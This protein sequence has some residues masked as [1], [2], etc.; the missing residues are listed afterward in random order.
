M[1]DYLK[2][3][4]SGFGDK[5]KIFCKQT[6]LFKALNIHNSMNKK[7]LEKLENIISIMP[8]SEKDK[9]YKKFLDIIPDGVQSYIREY[10]DQFMSVLVEIFGW[11][12]LK[13]YYQSY[14]PEFT[15]TPDLVVADNTD[16]PIAAMECKR[17]RTS[18]EDREYFERYQVEARD[19][20]TSIVSADS[21]ENPFLRKLM[22]TLNTA[23]KQLNKVK[24]PNSFIFIH[25]SWDVSAWL[26]KEEVIDRIKECATAL[27]IRGVDLIAFENYQ[28][29]NPIINT[30][31]PNKNHLN[32]WIAKGRGIYS[33]NRRPT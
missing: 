1:Y 12:K 6:W 8:R 22:G 16:K 29:D 23:E 33:V 28:P 19:V 25:F 4:S 32:N 5:S 24:A 27:K 31:L 21:A 17:I 14:N 3:V 15:E 13:E 2:Q 18:D 11:G 7:L 10:D 9:L 26:Q 30:M 20:K